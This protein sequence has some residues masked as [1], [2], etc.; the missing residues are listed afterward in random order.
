MRNWKFHIESDSVFET[1]VIRHEI[2]NA[3]NTKDIFSTQKSFQPSEKNFFFSHWIIIICHFQ[4][5]KIFSSSFSSQ[6]NKLHKSH[7]SQMILGRFERRK[8]K[9]LSKKISIYFF[10]AK[11]SI[12]V[13]TFRFIYLS[14]YYIILL[15]THKNLLRIMKKRNRRRQS[16]SSYSLVELLRFTLYNNTQHSTT[17][18]SHIVQRKLKWGK[19]KIIRK[20]KGEEEEISLHLDVDVVSCKFLN[21]CSTSHLMSPDNLLTFTTFYYY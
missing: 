4:V 21:I 3:N 12:F 14:L 13:M 2:C 17:F 8:K 18:N 9:T 15:P 6:V 1:I 16:S 7:N 10:F 5:K 19:N 11:N 20:K